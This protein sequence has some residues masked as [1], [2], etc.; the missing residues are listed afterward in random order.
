MACLNTTCT[1]VTPIT[2][3][4]ATDADFVRE[5]LELSSLEG[6]LTAA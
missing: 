2:L 5:K 3:M 4:T 6:N 1:I